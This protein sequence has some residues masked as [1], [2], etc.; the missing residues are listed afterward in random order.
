MPFMTSCLVWLMDK[1]RT[2]DLFKAHLHCSIHD[3]L[4]HLRSHHF[5]HCNLLLGRLHTWTI[6]H[7][8]KAKRPSKWILLDS[9]VGHA[10]V[11]SSC[12]YSDLSYIPCCRRCP[13]YE[14]LWEWGDEPAR[15]PSSTELSQIWWCRALLEGDQTLFSLSPTWRANAS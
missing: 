6:P 3:P 12:R 1:N 14:Q 13:S 15:S 7:D 8:I 5:D 11:A 9:T 4:C 2:V 10:K